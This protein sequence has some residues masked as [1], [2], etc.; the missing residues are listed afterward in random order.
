MPIEAKYVRYSRLGDNTFFISGLKTKESYLKV[1]KSM[2][3]DTSWEEWKDV[4][5]S[6]GFDKSKQP[7]FNTVHGV[8]ETDTMI[9]V[10]GGK[11][12][13]NK[14][15]Q[16]AST[17]VSGGHVFEG[18]SGKNLCRLTMLI[19]KFHETFACIQTYSPAGLYESNRR[20]GW[21]KIGSDELK[22]G[23]D[24][25]QDWAISYVPLTLYTSSNAPTNVKDSDLNPQLSSNNIPVGTIYYDTTLKKIR[26]YTEEGWK[27]LSFE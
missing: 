2:E 21:V 16:P 12:R 14:T 7:V 4:R 25:S 13:W 1:P 20:F 17:F 9:S 3:I 23:F 22:K 26:V 11:G 6:Y 19:G 27:N 5:R 15:D 8:F 10:L 24:F 18:W